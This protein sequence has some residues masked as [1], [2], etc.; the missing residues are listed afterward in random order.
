MDILIVT[1]LGEHLQTC[2]KSFASRDFGI[3]YCSALWAIRAVASCG[4][5]V[6]D[7]Y[8]YNLAVI[9]SE[10][11]RALPCDF[12]DCTVLES[13]VFKKSLLKLVDGFAHEMQRNF[14]LDLSLHTGFTEAKLMIRSVRDC[15]IMNMETMKCLGKFF[16]SI[17]VP[18]GPLP[19]ASPSDPWVS[20]PPTLATASWGAPPTQSIPWAPPPHILLGSFVTIHNIVAT[21][22]LNGVRG[23]VEAVSPDNRFWV[24]TELHTLASILGD[25]LT[26][27]TQPSKAWVC[28]GCKLRAYWSAHPEDNWT[29]SKGKWRCPECSSNKT[30]SE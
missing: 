17:D 26:S 8:P 1:R 10:D 2:A 30:P 24:K 27:M 25:N 22:Q 11:K 3:S 4:Q 9:S 29:G 7:P 6:P 18:R 12:G 16:R 5:V 19:S 23:I 14:G 28:K 15:G 20:H 21:P 13:S